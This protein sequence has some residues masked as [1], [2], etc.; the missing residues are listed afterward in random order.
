MKFWR[1]A[2]GSLALLPVLTPLL[3]GAQ[4]P[5]FFADSVVALGRYQ[6]G[7]PGGPQEW[8]TE[9]SG[10][11]YGFA[12]DKETD[13]EKHMYSVYLVTNRHVLSNHAKIDVRLN[14]LKSSDLVKEG[15]N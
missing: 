10:F 12:I 11:L 15:V 9:A 6:A 3:W 5:P 7:V 14:P 1:V 13:T 4:I 2:S 8:T